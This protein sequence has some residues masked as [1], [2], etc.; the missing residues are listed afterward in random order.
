[1]PKSESEFHPVSPETYADIV[2]IIEKHVRPE[3]TELF[4]YDPRRSRTEVSFQGKNIP[5]SEEAKKGSRGWDARVFWREGEDADLRQLY[6]TCRDGQLFKNSLNY[7]D[8]VPDPDGS[9]IDRTGAF[10]IEHPID[11]RGALELGDFISR[12][13][14]YSGAP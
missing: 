9:Y 11:E 6:F 14:G 5:T 2:K 3:G 4:S 12:L 1:M 13:Q 10:Q 7:N 8:M